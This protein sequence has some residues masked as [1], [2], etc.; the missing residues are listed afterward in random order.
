MFSNIMSCTRCDLHQNQ[1]PLLDKKCKAD[2]FWVGLSAKKVEDIENDIP[3]SNDTNSG[4][5]INRIES[6]FEEEIFYRTNLVKC[7]PLDQQGKL[8]YPDKKEKK[9]CFNNLLYEI[10]LINPKIIFLLGKE[11][12]NFILSNNGVDNYHLDEE[13]NYETYLVKGI[14]YVPVHHPSFIHVYRRKR[15][16]EYINSISDIIFNTCINEESSAQVAI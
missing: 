6:R 12:S 14:F 5:I 9:V 15:V 4:K 16:D 2:V 1:L 11:V 10:N 8:R 7:V 3:L 13:Y